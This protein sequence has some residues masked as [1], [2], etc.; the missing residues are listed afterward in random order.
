MRRRATAH[1]MPLDLEEIFESERATQNTSVRLPPSMHRKLQEIAKSQ[2]IPVATLLKNLIKA[3][4]RDYDMQNAG[5]RP[6]P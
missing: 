6:R 2:K 5:K 1:N 3:L 4:I